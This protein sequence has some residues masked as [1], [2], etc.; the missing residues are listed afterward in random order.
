MLTRP[1]P[2]LADDRRPAGVPHDRRVDFQLDIPRFNRATPISRDAI[3][4]PP[5]PAGAWRTSSIS[6]EVVVPPADAAVRPCYPLPFYI[7]MATHARSCQDRNTRRIPVTV[8]RNG[9]RAGDSNGLKA[10]MCVRR[11][12]PDAWSHLVTTPLP[13]RRQ[14]F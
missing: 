10:E 7:C 3:P 14:D 2:P 9:S 8:N 4:R 1:R 11:T 5:Q 13:C 12:T 6:R